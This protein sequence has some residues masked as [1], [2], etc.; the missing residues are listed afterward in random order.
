MTYA[1]GVRRGR[2]AGF[3]VAFALGAITAAAPACRPFYP[4]PDRGVTQP[5]LRQLV[6]LTLARDG[7]LVVVTIDGARVVEP[8]GRTLELPLPADPA[9][10]RPVWAAE[11]GDGGSIVVAFERAAVALRGARAPGAAPAWQAAGV[12]KL[13]GE[14]RAAAMNARVP[15]VAIATTLG[16]TRAPLPDFGAA[17]HVPIP[18]GAEAVA[19]DGSGQRLAYAGDHHLW[20]ERLTDGAAPPTVAGRFDLERDVRAIAFDDPD[21][22]IAVLDSQGLEVWDVERVKRE[23]VPGAS[24][25]SA[26]AFVPTLGAFLI[27]GE[28]GPKLCGEVDRCVDVTRPAPALD[29]EC[30]FAASSADGR[31]LAVAGR[32]P[33]VDRGLDL[34][35]GQDWTAP[36]ALAPALVDGVVDVKGPP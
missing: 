25:A 8:D 18:G 20:I 33:S 19:F 5:E 32:H 26:L 11:A 2:L 35:A 16:V 1:C 12:L 6:A 31:A 3:A 17:R 34:R 36:I 10:G 27:C 13:E 7:A 9:L 30:V 29:G 4:S 21:G 22:L 24:P 28:H 14:F 23:R 15:E